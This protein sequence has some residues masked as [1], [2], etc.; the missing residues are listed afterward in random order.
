MSEE[1]TTYMTDD[2]LFQ[3]TASLMVEMIRCGEAEA[4]LLEEKS[5]NPEQNTVVMK[6]NTMLTFATLVLFQIV[7]EEIRDAAVAVA[8]IWS[9]DMM[10]DLTSIA[11]KEEIE[12]AHAS[13][14]DAVARLEE[15]A[16]KENNDS[17]SESGS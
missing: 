16:N 2:A 7:E 15:V 12:T 17:S 9:S 5:L 6:A 11:F 10:R 4:V 13:L 1:D 3:M 14:N 8:K